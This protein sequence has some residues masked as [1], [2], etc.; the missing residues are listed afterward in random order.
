VDDFEADDKIDFLPKKKQLD[1]R[2]E[3]REKMHVQKKWKLSRKNSNKSAK[4][5]T[6]SV[7]QNAKNE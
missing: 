1:S 5:I 7:S 3:C 6:K 2:S 4:M